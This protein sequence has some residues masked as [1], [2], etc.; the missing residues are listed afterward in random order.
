M[1]SSSRTHVPAVCTAAFHFEPP[2]FGSGS[3]FASHAPCRGH[4][5]ARSC[6]VPLP[7]G[8][9]GRLPLGAPIPNAGGS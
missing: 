4:H 6:A 8:E 1:L 7:L 9:L 3:G 2:A 5:P